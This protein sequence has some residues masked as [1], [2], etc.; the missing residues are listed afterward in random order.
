V[1]VAEHM[2]GY[3][4]VL[5]Q[6]LYVAV[7]LGPLAVYAGPRPRSDIIGESLPYVPGG[8]EVASESHVWVCRAVQ[9][10]RILPA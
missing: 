3:W 10:V 9:G 6:Y 1:D 8:D 5:W 7:D 2:R 4:Y